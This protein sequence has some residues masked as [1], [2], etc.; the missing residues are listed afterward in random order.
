MLRSIKKLFYFAPFLLSVSFAE[1]LER[2]FIEPEKSTLVFLTWEDYIDE[3]LVHEFEKKHH[4]KI[5]FVYFEHD[6]ERDDM[7]ASPGNRV[8]DVIMLDGQSMAT[9]RR[10]GWLAPITSANVPNIKNYNDMWSKFRPEAVGYSVPYAWGTAGIAYRKDLVSSPIDSLVSLFEPPADLRHKIIMTPQILEMVPAA[11]SFLGASPNSTNDADLKRAEAL[12]LAQRPYVQSYNALQLNEGS[13]LV[14]GEAF[15]AYTYSSDALTLQDFNDNIEYVVPKEGS[16]LWID[17]L[18]V[19]NK[20]F[21]KEL[22][23]SFLQFMSDSNVIAK[24]METTY[25]ASFNDTANT[26][27]SEEIRENSIVFHRDISQLYFLSEP[28]PNAVRKMTSIL[29]LLNTNDSY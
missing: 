19:S 16:P 2:D 27:V 4:A 10:L 24:N 25:S 26:K 14:T 5:E 23:L 8:F 11:L 1:E 22:A 12:L 29:Q 28:K 21:Q 13:A 3:D 18:V 9:Y 15:I 6:E 17:F 20:S 7:V